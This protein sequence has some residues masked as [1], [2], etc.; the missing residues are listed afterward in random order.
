MA[1]ITDS[2]QI[3]DVADHAQE[4][5]VQHHP[6]LV[7]VAQH[8]TTVVRQVQGSNDSRPNETAP[9]ASAMAAA[10]GLHDPAAL[11][12]DGMGGAAL[13]D[14]SVSPTDTRVRSGSRRRTASGGPVCS[15]SVKRASSAATGG[16]PPRGRPNSPWDDDIRAVHRRA[17]Y[18]KDPHASVQT[19]LQALQPAVRGRS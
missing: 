18:P 16:R 14:L 19:A 2:S 12:T 3:T 5:G 8:G 9:I 7:M 1:N 4:T 11:A 15:S 6:A 13:F 10:A 17:Q